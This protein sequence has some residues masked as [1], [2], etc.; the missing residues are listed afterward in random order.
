MVG[1]LV[2]I[3]MLLLL[4]RGTVVLLCEN[5]WLRVCLSV[6]A[7][8]FNMFIIKFIKHITLITFCLHQAVAPLVSA[9]LPQFMALSLVL[10]L[11]RA[12]HTQGYQS[13]SF[14]SP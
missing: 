10:H 3:D 1:L 12:S 9:C 13:H 6:L 8:F 14:S 7:Y 5:Y 4:L 11:F 2:A